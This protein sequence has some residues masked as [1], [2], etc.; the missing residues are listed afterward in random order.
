ME[1]LKIELQSEQEK[2]VLLNDS[3]IKEMLKRKDDYL[4][5]KVTTKPWSEIKAA[6]IHSYNN[7]KPD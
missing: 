5:G 2:Q 6:Y 4:S 3:E 7:P 1:T